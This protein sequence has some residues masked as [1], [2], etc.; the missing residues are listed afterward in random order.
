MEYLI[1]YSPHLRGK[2]QAV[3]NSTGE[4]LLTIAEKLDSISSKEVIYDNSEEIVYMVD[5]FER[6][7]HH[8]STI[9]DALSKEILTVYLSNTYSGLNLYVTSAEDNI[10]AATHKVDMSAIHLYKHGE[11][12][13]TIKLKNTLFGTNYALDIKPQ[14]DDEFIHLFAIVITK[15]LEYKAENLQVNDAYA[16]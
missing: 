16:Y 1:K 10:Y 7:D 5:S 14:R 8:Q 3:Y 4:L 2:E 12:V 15:L 9:F 11:I 6:K 13:A